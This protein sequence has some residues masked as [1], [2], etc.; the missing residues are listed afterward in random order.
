MFIR[1]TTHTHTH[2]QIEALLMR[3]SVCVCV[4]GSLKVVHVRHLGFVAIF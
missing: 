2:I 1:Q 4:W 3:E